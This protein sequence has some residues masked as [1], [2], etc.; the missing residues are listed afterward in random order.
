[1]TDVL[2]GARGR[3]TEILAPTELTGMVALWHFVLRTGDEQTQTK[4]P[5]S[6]SSGETSRAAPPEEGLFF[7]RETARTLLSPGG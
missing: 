7:S 4:S 6:T 3:P 2:R 1:M 5:D